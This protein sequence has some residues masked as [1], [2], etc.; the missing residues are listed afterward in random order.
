MNKYGQ[1]SEIRR[2]KNTNT[3]DRCCTNMKTFLTEN[4]QQ[5]G[6]IKSGSQIFLT[7]IPRKA[8][9]IYLWQWTHST[10]N[11][12]DAAW[13]T[14]PVC[15]NHW[16]STWGCF[17][18]CTLALG[19]FTLFCNMGWFCSI[20]FWRRAVHRSVDSY[21]KRTVTLRCVTVLSCILK[22]TR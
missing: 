14:T 17:I 21:C 7:Y 2:H 20:S 4:L 16:Y 1:L 15:V 9:C 18:S 12:T 5:I 6:Q 10:Q 13:K 11:K 22:T 19:L 3:W 8:F